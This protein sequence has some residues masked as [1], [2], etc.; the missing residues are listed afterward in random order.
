MPTL[1]HKIRLT[2]TLEQRVAMA[3]AC[4][5]ARFAWNWALARYKQLKEQGVAK[6]SI[7]E[8]KKEF[9]QIKEEQFPWIYES[10]KDANQRPFAN[11]K[12]ALNSYYQTEAKGGK[13]GYPKFKKKGRYDSFY[14]SNDKFKIENQLVRLPVIGLVK[15]TEPLRFEG[16]ILSG[17]V[18]RTANDWF[19]SV[20]IQLPETYSR[21]NLKENP[22]IGI[23][24][25]IKT[26][27]VTSDHTEFQAPKPLKMYLKRLKRLSRRHSNKI[28]GS[29]NREKSAV[30]LAKLHQRISNIRQDF[31]HKLT[32]KLV[33]ENQVLVMETL[34]VKGMVKNR[35]LSRAI[36]DAGFGEFLRQIEYKAILH[37]RAIIK[38]D[39][40]FPSSKTCNAC[41][42]VK[43]KLDLSERDYICESCGVIEDRDYNA[44]LNLRDYGLSV[45]NNKLPEAIGDVKPV[46]TQALASDLSGVKLESMKQEFSGGLRLTR[47]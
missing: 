8:L 24:L 39:R 13:K 30:R 33:Q 7:N 3:K 27:A 37:N 22:I 35:R 9:N 23:D 29:H 43:T 31:I 21:S 32:T 40:W 26:F 12:K 41:G 28:K 11:L 42:S 38:A 16:K 17:T 4:G 15:M 47:K 10:P 46:E 19:L 18:S 34:N 36:S 5:C 45:L 6:V 2:P 44:A 20:Q 1:S 14:I 25:G